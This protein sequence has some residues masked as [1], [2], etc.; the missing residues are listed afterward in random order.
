MVEN[1]K[2]FSH[3]FAEHWYYN[4]TPLLKSG[5]LW[6]IRAGHNIAKSNYKMGPRLITYFSIHFVLEGEGTFQQNNIETTINKGDLFCLFP[7][8]TH[9]YSTNPKHKLKMF[10]LAFDGKQAL[11]LLNRTGLTQYSSY[12]NGIL[13]DA[14]ASTIEE[15]SD[16][17]QDTDEPDDLLF[18]SIIYKLFHQLYQQSIRLNLSTS[19]P[20]NWLEKG[21][22]YMNMHFAENITVADVAKYIDI[23]RSYFTTAYAKKTGIT[24]SKYIYKL[25]MEKA[26]ELITDDSHTIT[27]IALTL[28]YSDLYSFSRAFKK[29][30]GMSPNQYK[31][32]QTSEE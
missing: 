24:P 17:F 11:P 1:L 2:E 29:F 12:L 25:R 22:D 32:H 30:Y 16:Y 6:P 21:E 18:I 14:I 26:I 31:K 5:G 20:S 27:E 15:L 7:N 19:S 3:E 8:Q 28:G 23:N 4:P 13:N 9:H 10:W